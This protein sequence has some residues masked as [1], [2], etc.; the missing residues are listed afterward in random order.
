MGYP[1][2]NLTTL[3]LPAPSSAMTKAEYKSVY[4]IDLD[5]IDIR[6][7]KLVIFGKDKFPIAQIKEVEDGYEIYFNGHILSITDVVQTSDEVYDVANS[8]PIYCHPIEFFVNSVIVGTCLIFNNS[9]EPINSWDKLKAVISSL[10]TSDNFCRLH[11]TASYISDKNI[12]QVCEIAYNKTLQEYRAVGLN[13]SD[14]TINTSIN[15]TSLTGVLVN[16]GV[17]KIN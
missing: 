8:K 6:S 4:G 3:Q 5:A 15:I 1:A 7:F 12:Y 10:P 13:T 17:N 11:V 16:D 2:Y 9:A 14:G